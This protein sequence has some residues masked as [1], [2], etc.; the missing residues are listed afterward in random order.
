MTLKKGQTVSSALIAADKSAAAG[1]VRKI[2]I[3]A[4]GAAL[5]KSDRL[6]LLGNVE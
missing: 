4:S 2:K 1:G 6:K 3:P 5:T